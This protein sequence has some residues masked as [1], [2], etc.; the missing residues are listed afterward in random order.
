MLLQFHVTSVKQAKWTSFYNAEFLRTFFSVR[1]LS[2]LY[3]IR[4]FIYSV[5]LKMMKQLFPRKKTLKDLHQSKLGLSH[6]ET[7]WLSNW[8]IFLLGDQWNFRF[9]L[10]WKNYYLQNPLYTFLHVSFLEGISNKHYLFIYKNDTCQ[11]WLNAKLYKCHW[12]FWKYLV[13]KFTLVSMGF[14]GLAIW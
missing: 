4:S 8:W 10:K 14:R 1:C 12:E 6:S 2:S 9:T 11:A 7:K 13:T 3:H 5:L